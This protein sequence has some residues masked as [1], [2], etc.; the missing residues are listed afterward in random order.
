MKTNNKHAY[1]IMAHN[2][3]EVLL[4]T[5]KLLDNERN[6]FYIHIDKKTNFTDFDYLK[7][8]VIHS[9]V[10][11]IKRTN[12]KWAH[13]SQIKCELSLLEAA[14]NNGHY[15]YYHLISGVDMPIKNCS[16]ILE[17]FDKNQGMEFVDFYDI[18]KEWIN[19]I[20][21]YHLFIFGKEK[22]DFNK[23][24]IKISCFIQKVFFINRIK[25][26]GNNI[27]YGSNWF[28]ITN[29]LA[30]YV[31]KKKSFIEKHFKYSYCG[32]ELF[33]Q[34]LVKNSPFFDKTC[35]RLKVNSENKEMQF[36]LRCIDWERGDPYIWRHQDY[37]Y[38]I[39]SQYLFARK[40]D[41]NI[42]NVIIDELFEILKQ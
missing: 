35:Y 10:F 20:K 9:K 26:I 31:L 12:V 41:N 1:L 28:S 8:A 5:M 19:R 3:F 18:K 7:N 33:L 11:F 23:M 4:K 36:N 39:N 40:F 24:F 30:N 32:D 25:D 27:A 21:Y 6:D 34:T 2:Q 37:N 29:D 16:S 22:N 15:Q 17:F 38:L 13:Y 42:D 14:A